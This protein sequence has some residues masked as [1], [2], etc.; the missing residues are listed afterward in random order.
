METGQVGAG[1]LSGKATAPSGNGRGALPSPPHQSRFATGGVSLKWDRPKWDR[2]KWDRPKWERRALPS[3][4]H[5]SRF[6]TGGVSL[7]AQVPPSGH[8]VQ[9]WACRHA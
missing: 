1:G 5:Q 3:T 6:A 8:A 4:P 7:P 9:A 2:P